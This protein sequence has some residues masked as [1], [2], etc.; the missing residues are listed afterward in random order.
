MYIQK[1][2]GRVI[3]LK[4]NVNTWFISDHHFGH[5]NI[6]KYCDRPFQTVEEMD[7][8]M[9][10]QWNNTV[11]PYDIVY[12][13]GDMSFNPEKIIPLLNGNIIF[14]KGN[15]DK[16]NKVEIFDNV[17]RVYDELILNLDGVEVLLKHIPYDIPKNFHGWLL[18]GHTH[19]NELEQ[20]PRINYKDKTI[21]VCVEL[22]DYKPINI[23]ILKMIINPK[24]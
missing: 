21:N 16:K 10:K 2:F 19:N 9:I 1:N 18:H 11:G 13:L 5:A 23:E 24:P 15:H 12:F 3:N 4:D 14:I 22:W 6:I 17:V 8:F 7:T 20:F